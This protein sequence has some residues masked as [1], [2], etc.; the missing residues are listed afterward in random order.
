MLSFCRR[1]ASSAST[2]V[3]LVTRLIGKVLPC[4]NRHH[5]NAFHFRVQS[6]HFDQGFRKLKEKEPLF[7]RPLEGPS[8]S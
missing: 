8:D 5:A 6:T 1:K 7:L 2:V 3:Q 4:S